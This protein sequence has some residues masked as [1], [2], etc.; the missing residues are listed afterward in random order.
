[1][2]FE[3]TEP[4]EIRDPRAMRALAHPLRLRLLE[5]MAREGSLTATRAGELTGESTASCSFHLRQLG[6]YGFIEEDAGGR[7]RRRPWR[8]ARL[9]TRWSDVQADEESAAAARALTEALLERDLASL[10]RYL[11][12]RDE[13]KPEWREA[14]L[15]S[16][17]QL[18]LT[19]DELE[20]FSNDYLALIRGYLDRSADPGRRP[21]GSRPVR[22]LGVAFPLPE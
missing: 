2:S 15:L 6:K 22:A 3:R 11:R 7:G 1:M 17:S 14:S 18:F 8:L 10:F 13:A 5:L 16:T 12:E 19:R 20:R 4:Y 9:D 21:P